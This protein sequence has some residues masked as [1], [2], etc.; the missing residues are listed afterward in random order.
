M[1]HLKSDPHSLEPELDRFSTLVAR[2]HEWTSLESSLATNS[3]NSSKIE[4]LMWL[5]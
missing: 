2:S 3:D 5:I 4:L 1:D